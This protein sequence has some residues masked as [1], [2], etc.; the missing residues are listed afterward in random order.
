[1][2]DAIDTRYVVDCE[3]NRNGNAVKRV[4]NGNFEVIEIRADLIL[5]S[6]GQILEQDNLLAIELKMMPKPH[7]ELDSDRE[8]LKAMTENTFGA[9]YHWRGGKLPETVCRYKFGVY[10]LIYA[11]EGYIDQ[12]YF[13]DGQSKG[14][15]PRIDVSSG[16]K[17]ARRANAGEEENV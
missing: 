10:L 11:G 16:V 1:M 8:R 3:Y 6:R 5:H 7:R 13:F 12:E 2:G 4:L 14:S 15:G 9:T 17:A